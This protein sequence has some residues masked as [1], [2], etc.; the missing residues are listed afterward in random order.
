MLNCSEFK[1]FIKEGNKKLPSLVDSS[2]Q[3][4]KYK[5]SNRDVTFKY[6]KHYN[7][8]RNINIIS[9]KSHL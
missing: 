6:F 8:T 2:R 9:T 5:N 1:I 3:F 4:K 7:S